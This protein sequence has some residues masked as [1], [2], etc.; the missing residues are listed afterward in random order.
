VNLKKE[1]LKIHPPKVAT[2]VFDVLSL[3]VKK[4]V[5]TGNGREEAILMLESCNLTRYFDAIFSVDDYI[6][7]KP[8]PVGFLTAINHFRVKPENTI[9]FEDS[10]SGIIAAKK[11]GAIACFIKEFAYKDCSSLADFS[12]ENFNQVKMF[13]RNLLLFKNFKFVNK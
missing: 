3:P 5:V 11:A 4:C 8:S 6:E 9:V 7:S 1:Y 13:L 2:G 10:E 12:F